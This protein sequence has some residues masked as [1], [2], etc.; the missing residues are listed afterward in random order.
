M[1][2]ELR[3]VAN[4]QSRKRTKNKKKSLSV[5]G[6]DERSSQ[7]SSVS[8]SVLLPLT[9]V[10]RVIA[11]KYTDLRA[12]QE[13]H[14]PIAMVDRSGDGGCDDDDDDKSEPLYQFCRDALYTVE[15]EKLC[16]GAVKRAVD[17]RTKTKDR[18]VSKVEWHGH[19]SSL[20]SR[21]K[22]VSLRRIVWFR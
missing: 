10:V 14:R 8:S 2:W 4:D 17:N 11:E 13:S 22:P 20:P 5:D 12:I 21:T 6:S 19:V 3:I 7:P 18:L 15:F 16:I 1:K 9:V